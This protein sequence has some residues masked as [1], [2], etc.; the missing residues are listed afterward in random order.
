MMTVKMLLS[1]QTMFH[2]IVNENQ[3]EKFPGLAKKQQK[4]NI[5]RVVQKFKDKWTFYE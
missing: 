1:N 4:K 5:C 2:S 3:S